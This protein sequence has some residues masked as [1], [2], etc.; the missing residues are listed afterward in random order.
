MIIAEQYNK[1]SWP[2]RERH[3]YFAVFKDGFIRQLCEWKRGEWYWPG[4]DNAKQKDI[5]N[6]GTP[7]LWVFV[8][9]KKG[10]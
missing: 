6:H 10:I 4:G 3:K 5:E 8:K 7:I 1:L 9:P 2:D